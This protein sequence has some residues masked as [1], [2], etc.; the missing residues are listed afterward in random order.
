MVAGLPVGGHVPALDLFTPILLALPIRSSTFALF[1]C[2]AEL[3]SVGIFW[4][5]IVVIAAAAAAGQHC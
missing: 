2:S 4:S 3:P 1:P 5:A